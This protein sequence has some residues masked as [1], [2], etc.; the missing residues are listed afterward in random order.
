MLGTKQIRLEKERVRIYVLCHRD[1][2]PR[3]T[4]KTPVA[5]QADAVGLTKSHQADALASSRADLPV[6]GDDN[7][8][9][10]SLR[11][12]VGPATRPIW[13]AH[14]ALGSATIEAQDRALLKTHIES[15]HGHKVVVRGYTDALGGRRVNERLSFARARAVAVLL[16]ALGIDRKDIALHAYP[17]CCGLRRGLPL[18]EVISPAQRKVELAVEPKRKDTS[19]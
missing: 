14:F 3:P 12:T 4:P 17:N 6:A 15:L 9:D 18:V 16:E 10:G 19:S 2:C 7:R 8:V 5:V 13:T 11:H 1:D